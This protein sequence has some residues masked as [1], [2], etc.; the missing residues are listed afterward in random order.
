MGWLCRKPRRGIK[1][2]CQ[3]LSGFT[4]REVGGWEFEEQRM[5]G[6]AKSEQTLPVPVA[7]VAKV[8]L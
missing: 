4:R 1:K 3:E 6:P 2:S 8:I 5:S 7:A